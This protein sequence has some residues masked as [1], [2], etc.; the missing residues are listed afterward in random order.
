MS[1]GISQPAAPDTPQGGGNA[2]PQRGPQVHS[3]HWFERPQ[4]FC[5]ELIPQPEGGK[6]HG[7]GDECWC[8]PVVVKAYCGSC[9]EQ[10]PAF[11]HRHQVILEQMANDNVLMASYMQTCNHLGMQAQQ[12]IKAGHH[13]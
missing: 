11:I 1:N 5:I 4:R 6:E 3:L 9:L 8:T 10:Y 13:G 7:L 12:R 2:H